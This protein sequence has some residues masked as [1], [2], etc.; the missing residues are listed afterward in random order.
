M[1]DWPEQMTELQRK[2]VEQQQKLLSDWLDSMKS[3][4]G[5]SP[6]ASWRKAADIMEQQVDSALDAQKQ[7]LMAFAENIEN[8]EGA[9]EA[10]TQAVKQ[11]E[12]G[13][14]QWAEVQHKM[15]HVWFDMLRATA[16]APQT[17]G[18][19]AM[20][21]WEDMVKRTMAVQEEW[22]SSWTGPRKSGGGSAGKKTDR[23]TGSR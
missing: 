8:V 2:W 1:S 19:T 6:R 16:P 4:G 11:L 7:S 15:W 10:Y 13:I 14:E 3:A 23:S 21:S 20:E 22:L 12:Q 17:P 18:E 5:E 9:P